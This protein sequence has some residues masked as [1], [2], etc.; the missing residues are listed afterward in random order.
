MILLSDVSSKQDL[1]CRRERRNMC[2]MTEGV[3]NKAG[4]RALAKLSLEF[5]CVKD[6]RQAP[7]NS[8]LPQLSE[9]VNHHPELL[10]QQ[11]F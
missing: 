6:S 11:E 2:G 1:I 10:S 7:Q 4:P 8:H 5:L 9:M 3:V